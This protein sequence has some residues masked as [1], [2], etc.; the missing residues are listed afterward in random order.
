MSLGPYLITVALVASYALVVSAAGAVDF[1]PE[2]GRYDVGGM[3][4][5]MVD[6]ALQA[7]DACSGW[8]WVFDD[9]EGAVWGT[10]FDTR[11][12]PGG[13]TS[14]MIVK[15]IYL[16]AI[17][18]STPAQFGGVGIATVDAEGCPTSLL[19]QSGPETIANCTS[20]NRWTIYE[21]PETPVSGKFA[22]TVTWGPQTGG[23]SNARFA[24]DNGVANLY[25][26]Q[27]VTGT[28]PGCATS[29]SD[30][31]DW[32][33][34]PQLSF[35][36]VTD[37]NHDGM[38]DDLCAIYGVPYG[39]AFSYP[40]YYSYITNNMLIGVGLECTGASATE[41]NSW[42]RIKALFE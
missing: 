27:G 2:L 31:S 36:Y 21:T 10:I 34:Q 18:T 41:P 4:H 40:Y 28:F 15:E 33:M 38:L 32:S 25:C 35:I 22:V 14:G 12:C 11:D 23:V 37:I 5:G 7:F 16:Y 42:G 6:C 1:P 39:L 24:L 17:C 26:S 13:C 20:G 9:V 8:I 30:C 29:A 19:Y 3:P